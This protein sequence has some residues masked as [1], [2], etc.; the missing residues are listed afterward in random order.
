MALWHLQM[1]LS[2][3]MPHENHFQMGFLPLDQALQPPRANLTG[4]NLHLWL[5]GKNNAVTAGEFD[6]T[7]VCMW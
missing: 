2:Q 4:Q 5:Q 3:Q 6:L 1:S 7:G